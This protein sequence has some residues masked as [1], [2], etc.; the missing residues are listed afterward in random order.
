MLVCPEKRAAFRGRAQP[1]WERS[2]R[3]AAISLRLRRRYRDDRPRYEKRGK[4]F[5][6]PSHRERRGTTS[7]TVGVSLRP[8]PTSTPKARTRRV[9][10]WIVTSC[11]T[12]SGARDAPARQLYLA[13]Y[14]WRVGK[15]AAPIPIRDARARGYAGFPDLAIA[16][17]ATVYAVW[18]DE[19]GS[20]R[21]GGSSSVYFTAIRNGRVAPN[22][23][24]A[25]S[26]CP[27]CRPTIVVAPDSTV[28]AAWRH[29]IRDARDIAVAVSHDGGRS[30]LPLRLVSQDGWK[31][32]G[33]PEA[34]PSLLIDRAA[35]LCGVVHARR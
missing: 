18:L 29:D 21:S 15:Y 17:D 24:I 8:A 5:R 9:L 16:P 34:G 33:C 10:R 28:Y 7:R 20:N 27:C 4:P 1:N 3:Y 12:R 35:P 26:T 6:K 19:R 13:V 30:F 23:R 22:V 14:D 25:S 31:L 2:N 32:H 11:S